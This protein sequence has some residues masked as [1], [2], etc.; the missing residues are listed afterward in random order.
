MAVLHRLFARFLSRRKRRLHRARLWRFVFYVLPVL[1]AVAGCAR[2]LPGAATR[3]LTISGHIYQ[4]ET[5]ALG[6]PGITN[7][8]ITISDGQSP[9]RTA[10]S[11]PDGFYTVSVLAGS[12]SISASKDGYGT[13]MS[14]FALVGDTV[15]NFSLAPAAPRAALP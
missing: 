10:L 1:A 12:I 14:E 4:Q 2:Q 13:Q 7:V 11:G 5:P 9:E 15:L 6:E 3:L 8:L